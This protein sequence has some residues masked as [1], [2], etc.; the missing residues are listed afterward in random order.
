MEKYIKL[1]M[2]IL[3]GFSV[4]ASVSADMWRHDD[5]N[6]DYREMYRSRDYLPNW[7]PDNKCVVAC[8][9]EEFH[10]RIVIAGYYVVNGVYNGNICYPE[11]FYGDISPIN[12]HYSRKC[13]ELPNCRD[14]RCWAGGDTG[15]YYH[16]ER[17]GYRR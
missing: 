16:H 13:R 10:H 4:P 9:K 8:Y 2:L 3:I 15:G 12:S 5:I 1:I 7:I 17:H 6:I 14:G 11:N